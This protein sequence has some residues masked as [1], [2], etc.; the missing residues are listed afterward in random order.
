[1][2][3]ITNVEAALKLLPRPSDCR[4]TVAVSDDF[5]PQNT[6]TYCVTGD[7]VTRTDE[8]PDLTVDIRTLGQLWIGYLSLDEAKYRPDVQISANEALLRSVFVRRPIFTTV[9]F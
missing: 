4:F 6:A 1:M 9:G 7:T 2:L 8:T 3:R 5:L